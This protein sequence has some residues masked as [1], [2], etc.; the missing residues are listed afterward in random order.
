MAK[1]SFY[2]NG[3]I[4]A[5]LEGDEPY[6]VSFNGRDGIVVPASGDYTAAQITNVPAGNIS[7]TTVQDAINELDASGI[8]GQTNHNVVVAASATTLGP[9]VALT[10]NQLLVG[11]TGADPVAATVSGD[12]TNSLGVFTIGNDKVTYAKMQNVSATSRVLGRI[13]A[14]AGDVEELTGANLDT[15]IGGN[16]ATLQAPG[17]W[18]V[19]YTDGSGV[20]TALATGADLTFLRSNGA[21]AAPSWTAYGTYATHVPGNWAVS[22]TN[23]SG[24]ATALALGASGKVLTSN[25]AAAAP[26]WETPA[27]AS[28]TVP[29]P[30]GRLT[31]ATATPVMVTTQSAK[32]TIYYAL[33]KHDKVPIYDGSSWTMTTFTELSVATTDTTKNPAAI[34][35]SK[36]N[37]WFVWND[38]GTLR[39]SHGPDWTSDTVRSAG[40]ALVRVNG[41]W[42]NNASITNGPAASRGTYVG[43]TRSNASSQ[44][45]YIFGAVAAGGTAALFGVWNMYNR[46]LVETFVGDSG[47]SW[48]YNSTTIRSSNA[49]TGR[50]I[51]FV[52][53]QP[54]DGFFFLTYSANV[55]GT[56]NAPVIGI[57]VDSTSVFSGA[58]GQ[59]S[60]TAFGPAFGYYAGVFAEGFHFI[61]DCEAVSSG[62]AVCTFYGDAGAPTLLQTGM[63]GKLR[64]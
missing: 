22:Y 50:R 33:Y 43:T 7:S 41:V 37:D 5:T 55:G 24:A 54:D 31:L 48:T 2:Q 6:V 49:S 59:G 19:F 27:S 26:T 29:D 39:L 53:G 47:D 64:M 28:G 9:G 25:G 11:A 17:N 60:T 35:A 20:L 23:G 14:G 44:L 45:D 10:D 38:A 57:G 52:T 13:T 56:T 36:V 61:Q 63:T 62:T 1:S 18:K 16:H 30:G 58:I 21:A 4:L 15:I 40:T 42:M 51:S 32:T 12:L 8:S 34:G 3:S 46:V